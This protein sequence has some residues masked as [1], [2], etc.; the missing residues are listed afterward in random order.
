VTGTEGGAVALNGSASDDHGSPSVTWTYSASGHTNDPDMNCRF[1]DPHAVHTTITCNDDGTVR[2]QLTADDGVNASV[3]DTATLTLANAPPKL[4]LTGPAS[5]TLY[6]AGSAVHVTAPFTDPGTNDT[7]T[8]TVVWDDGT[9]DT[10][11]ATEG[12]CNRDHTFPHPGMYTIRA[13][14]TDDDGGSDSATTMVVVYDP[15]AGWANVDGS[16]A[17]PA[18]A[19]TSDPSATGEIWAHLTARY[20]N[21]NSPTGRISIQQPG[22]S[23]RLDGSDPQWLVVTPDG[24]IAAKGTGVSGGTAYGWVVYGYQGCTAGRTTGC[25]PGPDKLRVVTW[26]LS[27]GANPGTATLYDNVASAGYDVDVAAPTAMI[28]GQVLISRP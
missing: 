24:K 12:T 9:T 21:P 20:Y 14:V 22:T 10:T 25:Q 16:T 6:R 8:C 5:W 23:L 15:N 26:P 13:T 7:H 27:A 18:G 1:A 3:T 28:S 4:T 17:S 19:L 11:P 2:L